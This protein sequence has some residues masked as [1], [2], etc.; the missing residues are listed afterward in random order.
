MGY[1]KKAKRERATNIVKVD[2]KREKVYIQSKSNIAFTSTINFPLPTDTIQELT[3]YQDENGNTKQVVSIREAEYITEYYVPNDIFSIEIPTN[4]TPRRAFVRFCRH[5]NIWL[6]GEDKPEKNDGRA[7]IVQTL[8]KL[9]PDEYK[10]TPELFRGYRAIVS[11]Y[12]INEE[13]KL[14]LKS[15]TWVYRTY[16]SRNATPST[17]SASHRL[18]ER[19]KHMKKQSWEKENFRIAHTRLKESFYR[20]NKT[21]RNYSKMFYENIR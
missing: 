1:A 4:S 5:N 20:Q 19:L 15:Q 7:R 16:L 17:A 2:S 11:F 9:T 14:R 8:Y 18:G 10:N 13:M 21:D 3:E 6:Y 12:G